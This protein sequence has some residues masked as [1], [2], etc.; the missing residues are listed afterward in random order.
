MEKENSSR[1]QRFLFPLSRRDHLT[2]AISTIKICKVRNTNKTIYLRAVSEQGVCFPSSQANYPLGLFA[3]C[4]GPEWIC[5]MK[6]K[7]VW[8]W[9]F[10]PLSHYFQLST[11]DLFCHH[12]SVSDRRKRQSSAGQGL[13]VGRGASPSAAPVLGCVLPQSPHLCSLPSTS[14]LWGQVW[15]PDGSEALHQGHQKTLARS[16]WNKEES[17]EGILPGWWS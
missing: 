16:W 9:N 11:C 15:A 10:F 6:P 2:P 14:S 17:W 12:Q 5:E 3:S 4:F 7:L 13:R 1:K 8:R